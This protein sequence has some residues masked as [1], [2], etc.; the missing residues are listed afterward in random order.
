MRVS[1]SIS[2]YISFVYSAVTP[3]FL[4][5]DKLLTF[6]LFLIGVIISDGLHIKKELPVLPVQKT[7]KTNSAVSITQWT[8]D[9]FLDHKTL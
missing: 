5:W 8:F 7:V 3:S 1:I 9:V 2:F 6:Y 4:V